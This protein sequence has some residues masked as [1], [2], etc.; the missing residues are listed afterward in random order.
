MRT[1]HIS[2]C[3]TAPP[4]DAGTGNVI[5]SAAMTCSAIFGLPLP[6]SLTLNCLDAQGDILWTAC[7]D[8]H[9]V[10][11]HRTAGVGWHDWFA[12]LLMRNVR[13]TA[14]KATANRL[15]SIVSQR[16][17]SEMEHRPSGG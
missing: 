6:G 15:R 10:A 8:Y 3:K 5:S 9:G 12:L 13:T 16:A 7:Q 14:D 4:D 2:P 11:P 17:H 1:A